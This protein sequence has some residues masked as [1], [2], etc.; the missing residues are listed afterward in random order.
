[1]Y[2]NTVEISVLDSQ[3]DCRENESAS[4]DEVER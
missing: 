2:A 3:K 1:M 4:A